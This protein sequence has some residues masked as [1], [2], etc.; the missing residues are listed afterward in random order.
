M[1]AAIEHSAG[2]LDVA[3]KAIVETALQRGS[4]DNLT[5]QIIRIDQLPSPESNE[6]VRQIAELPVAPLLD[7]R[8]QFD[9]Y[10]ICLLYTSRCV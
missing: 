7:A 4:T 2:D 10:Q 6:M 1:A 8:M 5:I 3:A 9:G